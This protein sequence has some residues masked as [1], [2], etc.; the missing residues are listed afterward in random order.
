MVKEHSV[1]RRQVNN[2]EVFFYKP[3]TPETGFLF[4]FTI[5]GDANFGFETL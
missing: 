3:E 4:N 5:N 2:D 1:I